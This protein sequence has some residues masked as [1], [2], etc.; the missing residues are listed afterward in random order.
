MEKNIYLTTLSLAIAIVVYYF[1]NINILLFYIALVACLSFAIKSKFTKYILL[2]S[3]LLLITAVPRFYYFQDYK[4]GEQI[5]I[6]GRVLKVKEYE[7][8]YQKVLLKNENKNKIF[9]GF[10]NFEKIK[11]GDLL[12][13][14][15]EIIDIISNRNFYFPSVEDYYKVNNIS[16]NSKALEI[17]KHEDKSILRQ[18]KVFTREEILDS[19]NSNLSNESSQIIRKL[20]LADTDYFDRELYD[21]YSNTGLAHL[22][23]ISGLHIFLLIFVLDFILKKLRISYEMRFLT[24]VMMLTLY[25]YILNFPA[26]LS[27]A[28]LMYFL[29]N[30]FDIS[31]VKISKT[32]I[33][34]LSMLIILTIKPFSL[35]EIGFQLSYLSV[36]GILVFS[37]RFFNSKGELFSRLFYVYLSVNLMIFPILVI[38]FN[39]FNLF[40]FFTNI[41]VT[42]I[43]SL[44]LILSY[45]AVLLDILFNFS[46][47][48]LFMDNIIK[49]T[50]FYL[51]IFLKNFNYCLSVFMPNYIFVFL[52]YLFLFI[53]F[54]K[55]G[56]IY[57][58]RYRK[59]IAFVALVFVVLNFQFNLKPKLTVG[60]Y[61]VGQGDSCYL[62]YKDNYIQIDTGGTIYSSYNPG[63]EVTAKAIIKRGI[64]KIDLLILSHFDADHIMGTPK[65]IDYGLVD[66]ILINRREEGNLV[67]KK[68]ID[69]D[70]SLFYPNNKNLLIDKDLS[71]EFFNANPSE[72][73]S[74]NDSSLVVL[75]K[76]KNKKILF[77][78][79]ITSKVEEDI[80][81]KIGKIDILKVSHHG[82]DKSSSLNFLYTV[83]PEYSVISVGKNNSF[84]HPTK[85]VLD[86]LNTIKSKILRTDIEGEIVFEIGEDISYKSYKESKN[87]FD[88]YTMLIFSVII[89]LEFI[90]CIKTK[91]EFYEL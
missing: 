3:F 2:A 72:F 8:G 13:G 80:K 47:I 57:F 79:D 85:I 37:D 39:N 26:S 42:P 88:N 71:L 77:T 73:T 36:L 53:A 69:E 4:V 41:L 19:V 14:K 52:Y 40:S 60:F 38:N 65:L 30:L 82:S 50:N 67:Y 54:F 59:E 43:I 25:A 78:G 68:I 63:E 31:R 16:A 6:N 21:L 12:E 35:F 20:I 23:A 86:N 24:I 89:Y 90:Y 22:L 70:V 44:I 5:L 11:E 33:L 45:I 48:Y 1:F 62:I 75:V 29:S 87:N 51:Y 7:N 61:D 17:K 56:K 76:Y 32:A 84:G 55:R 46:F 34:S 66:A 49:A 81:D 18:I 28:L 91:E 10:K 15:V 83:R 9:I 27:R 74:S 64:N 58:Y